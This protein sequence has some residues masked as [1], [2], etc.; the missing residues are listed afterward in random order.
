MVRTLA[1][2]TDL[3]ERP[4]RRDTVARRA[5]AA[6]LVG[7]AVLVVVMAVLAWGLHLLPRW[8]NPFGER[9]VDRSQ[10][11]LLK[12]IQDLHRFE[13]AT[14]DFQVV[15]DLE[16]DAKF[17]PSSIRGTRTLFVGAG[18]VD[19][20]V[21]FGGLDGRELPVSADRRS[22]TVR[23]PHA[24]LEPAALDTKRSYVF[25]KQRGLL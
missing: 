10:P 3:D 19:A 17:L 20:Y 25:A 6:G 2:P 23:L 15:V 5:G 9:H 12:S 8:S 21:D 11:V 13:G 4:G 22:V 14:G 1:Q 16:A 24:Q 7:V 18:R